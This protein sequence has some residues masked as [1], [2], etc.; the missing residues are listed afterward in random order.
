MLEK[1]KLFLIFS[2]FDY[3]NQDSEYSI[4]G[5]IIRSFDSEGIK[6]ANW[7]LQIFGIT[8]SNNE[9][10]M[11]FYAET[12]N[13]YDIIFIQE[14]RDQSGTAFQKLCLKLQGYECKISSRAGRTSSKE[15][16]GIIFNKSLKLNYLKDY[17]PDSLNRWERPPIEANFNLGSYNLTIFN[18]H[19]KPDD[20]KKELD[21]LDDVVLDKDYVMVFGDLNADCSYYGNSKEN[22]FSNWEWVIKDDEDTTSGASNCAYDRIIINNKLSSKIK[23]YGIYNNI[24]KNQSDHYLIWIEL[25][26]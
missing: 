12:I 18:I 11:N 8:K 5:N 6:I 2:S 25:K 13:D 20:A 26:K 9:E 19:I 23:K 3:Y 16:Y 24:T 4:T 10:L 21:F 15:Q 22:E 1:K 17:N 14:I 7:N